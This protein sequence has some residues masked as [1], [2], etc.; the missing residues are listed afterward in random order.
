MQLNMELEIS[1][2]L[3]REVWLRV[4][5]WCIET[6]IHRGNVEIEASCPQ[7]KQWWQ[8]TEICTENETWTL[9]SRTF[10]S[11]DE[12]GD[13]ECEGDRE[14]AGVVWGNQ[15]LCLFQFPG[16][17]IRWDELLLDLQLRGTGV[18][19]V[20]MYSRRVWVQFWWLCPLFW[21]HSSASWKQGVQRGELDGVW[22][23][24]L[25]SWLPCC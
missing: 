11:K 21:I 6:V 18:H 3:N 9:T 22:R 7:R 10:T 25:G 5:W 12:V 1:R 23:R 13:R 4:R 2:E 15:T 8:S 17:C 20:W 19:F 14:M 16:S 24:A